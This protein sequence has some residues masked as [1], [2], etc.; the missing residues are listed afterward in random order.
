MLPITAFNLFLKF[1]QDKNANITNFVYYGKTQ[2]VTSS[3]I[4]YSNYLG[5]PLV[6]ILP[7]LSC[8]WKNSIITARKRSCGKVIF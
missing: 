7:I 2:K 4:W 3:G 6:L 8:L 5:K 1:K